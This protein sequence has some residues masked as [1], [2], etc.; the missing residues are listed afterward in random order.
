MPGGNKKGGKKHK[1]GKKQV[2]ENTVLHLKDENDNQEYAQIKACKG[3]CRFDLICFD[4]TERIGILCG[5]MRKRTFVNNRDVVLV[6]LR[7]FQDDKCDIIYKY[8]ESQ[9]LQLKSKKH[10]PDFI[11]LEDE[12]DFFDESMPFDFT[13]DMPDEQ[14][15]NEENEEKTNWWNTDK[16]SVPIRENGGFED[17]II[18]FDEI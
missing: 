8:D 16:K 9:V 3:N 10:I 15:E 5:K 13:T 11:K 4:G 1:K 7:D 6:S 12:N 2:I 17:S 18:D 14:E